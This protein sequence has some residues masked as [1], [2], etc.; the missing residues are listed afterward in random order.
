[1]AFADEAVP[2]WVD[3]VKR[4]YGQSSTKY[5]CVGYVVPTYSAFDSLRLYLTRIILQGIAS[6]PRMS[7]MNSQTAPSPLAHSPTRP[8]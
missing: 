8:F 5:A 1:M 4:T 2:R 7:V 3:E 6:A